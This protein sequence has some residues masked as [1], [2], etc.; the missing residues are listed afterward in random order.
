MQIKKLILENKIG[1]VLFERLTL[2][3]RRII[4]SK[5]ESFAKLLIEKCKLVQFS[6]VINLQ[7]GLLKIRSFFVRK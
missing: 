5:N 6:K 2:N 1:L 3:F 7:S 4:T